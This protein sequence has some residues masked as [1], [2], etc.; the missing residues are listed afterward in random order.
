L[1]GRNPTS[2]EENEIRDKFILYEGGNP[3]PEPD[4]FKWA[5][6]LENNECHIA[7]TEIGGERSFDHVPRARSLDQSGQRDD[8]ASRR[9][10]H[11]DM[12]LEGARHSPRKQRG[13]S[14]ASRTFARKR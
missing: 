5:A 4:T 11:S 10:M 9:P 3:I 2:S 12:G 7:H 8:R 1:D 6:W 14:E 13:G